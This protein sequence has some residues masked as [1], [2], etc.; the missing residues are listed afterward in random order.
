VL[1]Q[2]QR[3]GREHQRDWRDELLERYVQGDVGQRLQRRVEQHLRR[4]LESC[5]QRELG[6]RLQRELE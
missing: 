2:Q 3:V 5:F 1:G 6:W 4:D